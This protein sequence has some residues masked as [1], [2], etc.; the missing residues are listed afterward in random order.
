MSD[1]KTSQNATVDPKTASAPT[2]AELEPHDHFKIGKQ[3]AEDTKSTQLWVVS[4]NDHY[5]RSQAE[6]VCFDQHS[7]AVEAALLWMSQGV[8]DVTDGDQLSELKTRL[9]CM[10]A[11]LPSVKYEDT[12]LAKVQTLI[13]AKEFLETLDDELLEMFAS[14]ITSFMPEF[15]GQYEEIKWAATITPVPLHGHSRRQAW[16]ETPKPPP[17]LPQT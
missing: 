13:D 17:Q 11:H 2:S 10:K 14:G 1:T 16:A 7:A 12:H 3:T 5:G 8:T 4:K 15:N 9:A 6:S